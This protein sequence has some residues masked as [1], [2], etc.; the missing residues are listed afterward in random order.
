MRTSSAANCNSATR[1]TVSK[2]P[3]S[4]SRFW[5]IHKKAEAIR[6][7]PGRVSRPG[8]T[9]EPERHYAV[10]HAHHLHI[11]PVRYEVRPHLVQHAVHALH[12][13][14]NCR[15]LHRRTNRRGIWAG[16]GTHYLRLGSNG[17]LH[18]KCTGNQLVPTVG[19]GKGSPQESKEVAG[20]V[21][22]VNLRTAKGTGPGSTATW[23]G[24]KHSSMFFT[25]AADYEVALQLLS[26]KLGKQTCL[27]ERHA[28]Q[29]RAPLSLE[30]KQIKRN[31]PTPQT[32]PRLR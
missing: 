4:A 11:A 29:R 30:E 21:V 14:Q 24:R 25:I 13:H 32:S 8:L 15:R 9:L 12:A 17:S 10:L 28:S 6:V 2:R 26:H 18:H 5:S 7:A 19:L 27:S 16:K 23:R 31:E 3:C 20:R 1:A 22:G